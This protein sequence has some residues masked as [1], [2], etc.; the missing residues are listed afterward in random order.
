MSKPTV[1]DQDIDLT[2]DSRCG[3]P[4]PR[5]LK[6]TP[7]GGICKFPYKFVTREWMQPLATAI[8]DDSK[9]QNREWDLYYIYSN[10]DCPQ[11]CIFVPEAQ[12]E[13]LLKEINECFPD[14]NITVS[15]EI[16]DEGLVINFSEIDDADLRPRWLGK[17]V[18]R[19]QTDNWPDKLEPTVS[20]YDMASNNR[21]LELFRQ[22]LDQAYEI[23]RN[24]KKAAKKAKQE[25]NVQKRRGMVKELGRA[26]K[27]LGLLPKEEESLLPD[28]ASL[29]ISAL[30]PDKPAPYPF[31]N[32]PIFI[33]IDVEAFERPPNQITEVGVATLDTRNLKDVSPGKHGEGWQGAIRARHF[34]IA[35]YKHLINK[36][37]VEGCPEQFE[38]GKSEV[39]GRDNISSK[40]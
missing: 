35:E 31:E 23:G 30:D 6:F 10:I 11:P 13:A 21:D 26:Q 7:F 29:S 12:L 20:K 38:F 8:F 18:S 3:E 39:I 27:Y 28:I 19:A 34:R 32:E 16:R 15:Q 4:A 2:L 5:D 14:A 17:S 25:Q 9:I 1:N 24:R 33:A 36:D 37:F 40:V 22:K